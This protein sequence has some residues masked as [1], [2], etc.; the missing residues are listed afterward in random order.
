[1]VLGLGLGLGLGLTRARADHEQLLELEPAAEQEAKVA[2]EG[3]VGAEPQQLC[4]VVGHELVAIL[5]G[6]GGSRGRRDERAGA[7]GEGKAKVT[8]GVLEAFGRML[9]EAARGLLVRVR[10]RVRVR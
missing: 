5:V 10:V 2:G 9:G 3:E 4:L 1:M 7:A 8:H 6:G